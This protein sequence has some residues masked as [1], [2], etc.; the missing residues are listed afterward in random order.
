MTDVGVI[1]K[2]HV[3]GH[4]QKGRTSSTI[5]F[6]YGN[7]DTSIHRPRASLDSVGGIPGCDFITSDFMQKVQ[8]SGT[9][10]C[11]NGS[12]CLRDDASAR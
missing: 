8:R 2:K 12:Y 11:D 5:C 1:T 3:A 6:T 7:D 10:E 9:I 4:A